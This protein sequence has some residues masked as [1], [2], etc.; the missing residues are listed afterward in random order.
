MVQGARVNG[1][2]NYESLTDDFYEIGYLFL[3]HYLFKLVAFR[4]IIMLFNYL[5]ANHVYETGMSINDL[6]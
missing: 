2:S 4:L 3:M 6:N 1:G 5:C